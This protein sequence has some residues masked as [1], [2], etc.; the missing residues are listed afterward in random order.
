M[1]NILIIFIV[2]C[3]FKLNAQISK[4]QYIDSVKKHFYQKPKH[5]I[6]ISKQYLNYINDDKTK[7]EVYTILGRAHKIT[8]DIDS[9]LYYYYKILNLTDDFEEVIQYKYSIA[10]IYENQ[11][12]YEDA[13]E[14]YQ[15][16]LELS[17]DNNIDHS[18]KTI[19]NKIL[20]LKSKISSSKQL[21]QV[22]K[23]TYIK[24][25]EDHDN[26][27]YITRNELIQELLNNNDIALA[28][29]YIIES[30]KDTLTL[31]NKEYLFYSL[32]N[33][34]ELLVKQ[35]KQENVPK[36][37]DSLHSISQTLKNNNFLEETAYLSALTNFNNKAYTNSIK[38]L[39]STKQ[40][41][42]TPDQQQRRYKLLAKSYKLI[43]STEK[44]NFYYQKY[45]DTKDKI[46]QKRLYT[47]EK[48]HAIKLQEE[49]LVNQNVSKKAKLWTYLSIGLSLAGLF[50]GVIIFRN[51]IKNQKRFEDLMLRIDN[52]EAKQQKVDRNI[53]E[54]EIKNDP[55][56][57]ITETEI[58]V[59]EEK[60]TNSISTVIEPI[61]NKEEQAKDVDLPKAKDDNNNL[62]IIENDQVK[63]EESSSGGYV[64]DDDKVQE[65]LLKIKK[66]E[67]KK[68]YLRQDCTLGNMSKKLKTNT[69]YLSKV[70]NSHLNKS[71]STYINEL[72]VN[73]AIIE[74]KNNKRLRSY[75]VKG[76]AQE[77]GYKNADSFS[78]YFKAA[79]GLS[80]SVYIQ[81]I[82]KLS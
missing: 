24:E 70:I 11:E 8:Y 51:K 28:Q 62:D 20:I 10:N 35:N 38:A 12:L 19:N 39:T 21:V 67:D 68:Y 1:K 42:I 29:D 73:Y 74:I 53:F 80:P 30:L 36:Y 79:T 2:F 34:I 41:N 5:I 6:K 75:S 63:E 17:K 55:V 65:L 69:S 9:T 33:K 37:L 26:D 32:K 57:E 59:K 72:R 50:L 58:D 15:Q 18:I 61:I 81:K 45:V 3:S 4:Q 48:I 54:P 78:R 27:Y 77:M 71:F 25:K 66:L 22:L 13:I 46:S 47:L 52:H 76:I 14:Y 82:S 49:R 43:D 56:V 64:I 16:A 60:T 23:D 31:K 44:S 40:G 7:K